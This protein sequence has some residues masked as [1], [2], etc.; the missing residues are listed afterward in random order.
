MRIK[1][2]G[3][4]LSFEGEDEQNAFKAEIATFDS[5]TTRLFLNEVDAFVHCLSQNITTDWNIFCTQVFLKSKMTEQAI[6]DA[7]FIA[8][9]S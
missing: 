7:K 3:S 9:N 8:K 2:N 4:N 1:K 5:G 6:L